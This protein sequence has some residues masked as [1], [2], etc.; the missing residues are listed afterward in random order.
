MKNR[1]YRIES[2]FLPF[3]HLIL[4]YTLPSSWRNFFFFNTFIK[5]WVYNPV[6][7]PNNEIT[8]LKLLKFT[9]TLCYLS[10]CFGG[11]IRSTNEPI[12][13][14]FNKRIKRTSDRSSFRR[15]GDSVYERFSFHGVFGVEFRTHPR[16]NRVYYE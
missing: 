5:R 6:K 9:E 3:W 16:S 10:F 7:S 1:G 4:R 11:P 15:I 8:K 14:S 13:Q 2:L 12:D